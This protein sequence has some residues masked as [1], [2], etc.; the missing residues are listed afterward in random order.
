MIASGA[1]GWIGS[2]IMDGL[3]RMGSDPVELQAESVRRLA[4]VFQKKL[5]KPSGF[6]NAT[7]KP[8]SLIDNIAEYNNAPST[9]FVPARGCHDGLA[10]PTFHTRQPRIP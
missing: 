3:F 10:R 9:S 2:T 7:D 8:R 5:L 4:L 6:K 1:I